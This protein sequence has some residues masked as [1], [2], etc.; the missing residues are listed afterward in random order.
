MIPDELEQRRRRRAAQLEEQQGYAAEGCLLGVALG[1]LLWTGI[2]VI[3]W[4]LL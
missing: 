4:V 2:I 1:A 3:M